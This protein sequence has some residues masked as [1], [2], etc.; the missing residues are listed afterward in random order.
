MTEKKKK[1]SYPKPKPKRTFGD[2]EVKVHVRLRTDTIGYQVPTVS[3]ERHWT[4]EHGKAMTSAEF[5]EQHEAEI[6]EQ[7]RNACRYVRGGL[8]DSEPNDLPT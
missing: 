4:T 3:L 6:I 2:G 1:K 5:F 8:R 7:I